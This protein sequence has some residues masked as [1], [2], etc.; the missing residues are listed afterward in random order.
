MYRVVLLPII[1]SAYLQHLVFVRPLLLP[2]AI[3]AGSSNG[4]TNTRCRRCSCL[5]SWWWVVV[6]PEICRAVSRKIN[7]VTLHLV[8]CILQYYYDA[9]TREHSIAVTVFAIAT[10]SIW[11]SSIAFIKTQTR[12]SSIRETVFAMHI[13]SVWTWGNTSRFLLSNFIHTVVISPFNGNILS[14]TFLI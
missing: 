3:A 11:R 5:S 13:S 7:C 12:G 6:P 14:N 9:R 10:H 2:A 4:V 1:R 8:G